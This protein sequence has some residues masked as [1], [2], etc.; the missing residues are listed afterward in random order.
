MLPVDE[1]RE[2]TSL[3]CFT[4]KTADK[5]IPTFSR[6]QSPIPFGFRRSHLI[7]SGYGNAVIRESK[8]TLLWFGFGCQEL[9]FFWA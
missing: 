1:S 4:D 3:S 6:Y 8:Q 5:T 2:R 7:L 9:S